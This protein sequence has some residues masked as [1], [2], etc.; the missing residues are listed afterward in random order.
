VPWP[1]HTQEKNPQ[2]PVDHLPLLFKALKHGLFFRVHLIYIPKQERCR[3]FRSAGGFQ[4]RALWSVRDGIGLIGGLVDP[5]TV[6]GS[7]RIDKILK[8]LEIKH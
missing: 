7:V 3:A 1:L 6:L 2:Y 5:R 4:S 8:L